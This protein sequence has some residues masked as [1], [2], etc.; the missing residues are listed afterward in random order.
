[1]GHPCTFCRSSKR[2]E[3]ETALIQQRF[4]QADVAQ[5]LGVSHV[6]VYNHMKNHSTVGLQTARL[7]LGLP[8]KVVPP[9]ILDHEVSKELN[10]Y[11]EL[12]YISSVTAYL[13]KE[14][15]QEQNTPLTLR[16]L[17]RMESQLAF[18]AKLEGLFKEGPQSQI[19][20]LV[21]DEW[22]R[23][24]TIVL[25]TLEEY[26]EAREAIAQQLAQEAAEPTTILQVKQA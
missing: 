20:I 9:N 12:L 8:P 7:Q 18:V 22:T 23:L 6:A 15:M 1:M 3:L 4:S 19:N 14:A 25:T 2:D 16:V 17:E 24:K 5:Q 13:L 11:N 10:V 26:P 21:N